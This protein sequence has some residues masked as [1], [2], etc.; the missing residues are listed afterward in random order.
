MVLAVEILGDGQAM[1]MVHYFSKEFGCER[2]KKVA[3][4]EV[5]GVKGGFIFMWK[6]LEHIYGPLGGTQYRHREKRVG[7]SP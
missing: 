4:N 1:M 6:E 2:G 5:H 7:V 3:K